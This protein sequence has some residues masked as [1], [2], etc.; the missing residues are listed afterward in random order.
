MWQAA[1]GLGDFMPQPQFRIVP[2]TEEEAER[3][4]AQAPTIA[5]AAETKK[6]GR[7]KKEEKL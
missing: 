6:K 5:P 2:V 4:S 7:K 3:I 1:N